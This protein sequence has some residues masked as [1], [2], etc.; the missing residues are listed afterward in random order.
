MSEFDVY[1]ILKLDS[2]RAMLIFAG[3][4]L[5]LGCVRAWCV[6]EDIFKTI[7]P[8]VLGAS[9]GVILFI[10]GV[11]IPS[12][13]EMCAIKIVPKIVNSPEFST[14]KKDLGEVYTLGMEHIK[15][16]LSNKEKK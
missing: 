5:V 9:F 1:W 13:K 16:T 8:Y 11:M 4:V 3:I 12:T 6:S 2:I 14:V 15:T 10:T 7:T